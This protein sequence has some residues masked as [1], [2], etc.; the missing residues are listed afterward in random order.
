MRGA[1]VAV[2]MTSLR[3]GARPERT[4]AEELRDTL[5]SFRTAV[6]LGW[7]VESNWAD[8]VLFAI[9]SVAKP[10]A[11]VL[12]LLVM[13][14]VVSG[15]SAPVELRAFLV[16]GSALWVLVASGMQGLAQAVV[17]DRERYR[18]L[19]YLYVMPGSLL[20]TLLG[21]GAA[22]LAVGA[23]GASVTLGLTIPLLGLPLDPLAIDWVLLAA[24]L[25][26]G[27]VAI[28]AFGVAL[29]AVCLQVRQEA[30]NYPEAVSGALFLLSGAVFPIAVLPA[31]AQL[32]GLALPLTWWLEGV[33]RALFPSA[34]SG[35][36]GEGSLWQSLTGTS[37]P[38]GDALLV[39]LS[40]TTVASIVIAVG[41]YQWGEHRAKERGLI[42]QVTGS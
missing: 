3:S 34:P 24:S 38:G 36:G 8:P 17:E 19:R 32:I 15:G 11:G 31:I 16:A 41:A 10:V 6:R 7:A 14:E 30:W 2:D 42:D 26:L 13:L 12:I 25:G 35:I 21:R 27:I 37:V 1:D 22:R 39:A 29:S 20:V 40:L 23:V 28:E 4:R 5:R 9:Y 33:R 18:M